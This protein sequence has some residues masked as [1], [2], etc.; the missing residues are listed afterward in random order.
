MLIEFTGPETL[1][2]DGPGDDLYFRDDPAGLFFQAAIFD[3]P[4]ILVQQG[5]GLLH[6]IDDHQSPVFLVAFPE[7]G[8]AGDLF[9]KDV[10]LQ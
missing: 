10:G 1:H 7:Q 3:E 8:R 6:F 9:G 4:M 5:R 2:K